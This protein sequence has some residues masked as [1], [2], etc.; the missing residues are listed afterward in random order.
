MFPYTEVMSVQ[1][2]AAYI[3]HMT[4]P[5]NHHFIILFVLSLNLIHHVV[6]H[7]LLRLIIKQAVSHQNAKCQYDPQEG[8]RE[9]RG[10]SLSHLLK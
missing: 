7:I 1:I 2:R 3:D 8:S 4:V 10:F 5:Q 9:Q 6:H